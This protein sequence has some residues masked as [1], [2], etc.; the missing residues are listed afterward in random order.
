MHVTFCLVNSFRGRD[1][2][3]EMMRSVSL[4]F[5]YLQSP[6]F[7]SVL[8]SFLIM[9]NCAGGKELGWFLVR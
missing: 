3:T 9:E 4:F 2:L 7:C 8:L 1:R 5:F 6:F